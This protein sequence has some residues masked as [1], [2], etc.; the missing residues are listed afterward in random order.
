LLRELRA[1]EFA[2]R[3]V[4]ND[5]IK[6]EYRGHFKFNQINVHSIRADK[7]MSEFHVATKFSPDWDFLCTLRD[8]GR[9]VAAEWIKNH[10]ECIGNR[11]SVDLRDVFE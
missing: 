2:K 1:I 3:L 4:E 10:I 5:M 7:I 8:R 6:P 11:S 9:E